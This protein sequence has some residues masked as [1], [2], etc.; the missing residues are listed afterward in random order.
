MNNIN[1]P[2]IVVRNVSKKYRLFESARDRLKEALHPFSKRYHKEFCALQD[3]SFEVQLGQTIGILGRNGSG[4]STLLQIITGIMQ[5]T[6]GEVIVNGRIS[7]LLELG[8]GF[9]PDFTGRENSIF[10][11]EVVGLSREEIDRK[12]PEIEKF[13]DIGEFFNQPVKTYSSGMFVRVAFA[14]AINVDPDI[15]IIDEALSV[16]DAKFQNKCFQKLHEFKKKGKTIILV[17]H[18]MEAVTRLCD[19]AVLLEYGRVIKKGRPNEVTNVYFDILFGDSGTKLVK[20]IEDYNIWVFHGTY[21]ALPNALGEVNPY[22][23]DYSSLEGVVIGKSMGEIE[24]LLWKGV[25][26]KSIP[27]MDPR[28]LQNELEIFLEAIPKNDNCVNRRSYNKNEYRTG[29][30]RAEILDYLFV[31]DGD[32]DPVE[33]N[34]WDNIKIYIKIVFRQPFQLPVYGFSVK[35]IDGI[36]ICGT[37]SWLDKF[38][39]PPVLGDEVVIFCYEIKVSLRDGDFFVTLA[40]ADRVDNQIVLADHRTDIIHIRVKSDKEGDNGF[41]EMDTKNQIISKIGKTDKVLFSC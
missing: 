3:I 6:N 21:Y 27:V 5:P 33:I 11:A 20:S 40:I 41:I 1:E 25:K 14:A 32:Y 38:D 10:Q 15:L 19:Y 31:R 29:D 26:S 7:A 16:G 12:L 39:I 37:N 24:S 30:K 35:T 23:T 34:T 22:A 8:A 4:K 17:T 28:G 2:A 13:A 18:D 36:R 9:N